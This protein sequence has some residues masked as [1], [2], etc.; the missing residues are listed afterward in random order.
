MDARTR[1]KNRAPAQARPY[2]YQP[3]I[4][5]Q[6]RPRGPRAEWARCRLRLQALALGA[7]VA[8][9]CALP[10]EVPREELVRCAPLAEILPPMSDLNPPYPNPTINVQIHCP[11]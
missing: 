8:S 9:G 4:L 11:R 7:I 3:V 5:V 10:V 1:R 6:A 2:R